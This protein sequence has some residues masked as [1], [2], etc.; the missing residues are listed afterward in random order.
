[1]K[2]LGID[3][4]T[5]MKCEGLATQ[6]HREHQSGAERHTD[7][8]S[9]MSMVTLIVTF[10][11]HK[12]SLSTHVVAVEGVEDSGDVAAQ[13]ADGDAGVVQRHPAAAGL[14][15]AVAAEQ[16]IAHR[17]QHA[18]LMMPGRSRG[19]SAVHTAEEGRRHVA[20]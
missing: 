3:I 5:Q 9:G 2:E 19:E 6:T 16:V 7:P 12:N 13:D 4:Y 11:P 14:L 20:T 15:R 17:A 8:S 18:Q 1:M 10:C